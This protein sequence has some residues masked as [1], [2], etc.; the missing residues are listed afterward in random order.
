M[1]ITNDYLNAVST[2]FIII[3]TTMT[4]K[5]TTAWLSYIWLI[6]CF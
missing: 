6:S 1:N 2:H 4:T 3:K 5:Q